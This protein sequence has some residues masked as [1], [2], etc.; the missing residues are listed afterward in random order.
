MSGLEMNEAKSELFFEGYFE[1]EVSALSD[2]IGIKIGVFPTRYLGLPLN[3]ARITMA[4]LQPFLEKITG[5]LHCWTVKLL[6]FAGKLRLIA[7]VIY[8]M[9]NFWSAVFVLPKAFYAKF[10]SICAAFLLKNKTSSAA[11]ERIAWKDVCKPKAEGG[12]GIRLLE[13]F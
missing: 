11:G 10:D 3:P 12:L 4:T 1:V 2:L 6:S 13:D 5:K 9:V 7:S 8:G